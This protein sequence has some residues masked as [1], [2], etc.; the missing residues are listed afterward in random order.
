MANRSMLFILPKLRALVWALLLLLFL[1]ALFFTL[2]A[3]KEEN[4]A[5]QS[6]VELLKLQRQSDSL[7]FATIKSYSKV[8]DRYV[9]TGGLKIN[10]TS[11][12]TSQLIKVTNDY[13]QE[14][15][16]LQKEKNALQDSIV[17]L[18][19]KLKT[20]E[21]A[22]DIYKDKYFRYSDSFDIASHINFLIKRHYGIEYSVE[23]KEKWN[24]FSPNYGKVDTALEFYRMF[25]KYLIIKDSVWTIDLNKK[26][27]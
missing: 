1:A 20:Q 24:V 7:Y 16:I 23:R 25:G 22:T 9:D 10:G 3:Y 27:K 8:I 5:L 26:I 17:N 14:A 11:V 2:L 15:K 4:R 12:S 21:Y 19:A 13:I 6:K 18:I